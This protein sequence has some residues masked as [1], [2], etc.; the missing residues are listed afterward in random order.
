MFRWFAGV[1]AADGRDSGHFIDDAV[2]RMDVGGNSK[3][4]STH[5]TNGLVK[6]TLL[7]KNNVSC[8]NKGL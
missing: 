2:L 1:A 3:K 8:K 6:F 4:R 7:H 5:V